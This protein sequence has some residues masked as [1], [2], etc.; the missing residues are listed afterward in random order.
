MRALYGSLAKTKLLGKQVGAIKEKPVWKIEFKEIDV[1]GRKVRAQIGNLYPYQ[2][3]YATMALFERGGQL[4]EQLPGLDEERVLDHHVQ[5]A[6]LGEPAGHGRR[7]HE[8]LPAPP[9]PR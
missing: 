7:E 9:S 1:K 4:V 5:H 3:Y 8:R 2:W 6:L